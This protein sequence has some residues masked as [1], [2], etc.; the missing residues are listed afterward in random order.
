MLPRVVVPMCLLS[1]VSGNPAPVVV[2]DMGEG[3]VERSLL[4]RGC[5]L[6]VVYV[7]GL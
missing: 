1:Q 7:G 4:A 2:G 5:V 3:R 6:R